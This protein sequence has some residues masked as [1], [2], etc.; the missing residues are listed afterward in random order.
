MCSGGDSTKKYQAMGTVS[1]ELERL[2][3]GIIN[4][5]VARENARGGWPGPMPVF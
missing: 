2:S 4:E 3:R 1:H 5:K